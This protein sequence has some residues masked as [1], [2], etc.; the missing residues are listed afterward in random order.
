MLISWNHVSMH[1]LAFAARRY[2]SEGRVNLT[3][4]L[5]F[6]VRSLEEDVPDQSNEPT[7]APPREHW[8]SHAEQ[9]SDA[10]RYVSWFFVVLAIGTGRVTS[11]GRTLGRSDPVLRSHQIPCVKDPWAP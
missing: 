9:L 6:V 8:N 2:S 10:Q 5:G 7:A 11:T 4:S 1:P 3:L